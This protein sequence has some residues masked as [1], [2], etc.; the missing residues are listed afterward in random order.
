MNLIPP[1]RQ[2][3]YNPSASMVL[4][5]PPTFQGDTILPPMGYPS[6]ANRDSNMSIDDQKAFMK[7]LIYLDAIP[8]YTEIEFGSFDPDQANMIKMNEQ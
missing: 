8:D 7:E 2:N 5:A 4:S 1:V 6:A 3:L